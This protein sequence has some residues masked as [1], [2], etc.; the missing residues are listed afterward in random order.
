MSVLLQIEYEG[1]LRPLA[2]W[3]I[4]RFTLN[5]YNA[6]TEVLTLVVAGEAAAADP[7][8]AYEGRVV[9][10]CDGVRVFHGIVTQLPFSEKAA[11]ARQE[12][13]VS[14]PWWW[15]ENIVYGQERYVFADARRPSLGFAP[16][17]VKTPRAVMYQAL[18]GE[19]A[20]A[21]AQAQVAADYAIDRASLLYGGEAP[22]TRGTFDIPLLA[23]WEEA[24]NL[25]CAEVIRRCMRYCRDA[26]AYWDHS[27]EKPQLI[28]ERRA[29]LEEVTL[30]LDAGDRITD[31]KVGSRPD[32]VPRGVVIFFEKSIPEEEQNSGSQFTEFETQV[33]GPDPDLGVRNLVSVL[34][35]SGAGDGAEPVPAGLALNYYNS[36]ATLQW[37]GT[38]VLREADPAFDLMPGKVLNLSNGKA[39]WASMKA[40][41]QSVTIDQLTRQTTVEFGPAAQLGPQDLLDQVRLQKGQGGTNAGQSR[42]DGTSATPQKTTSSSG[43]GSTPTYNAKELE[44]C[45]GGERKK[46]K[47]SLV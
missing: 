10:W 2:Q 40:V 14:G 31:Y 27:G 46:I 16:A 41:I 8:F 42:R 4:E 9:V 5:A 44:I 23:P 34:R 33:A 25:S 37:E 20:S 22:F 36:L 11:G 38:V 24:Y 26:V 19:S 12:Y 35:L 1:E 43:I 18:S 47:V 17:P 13:I 28:I 7:V 45:E 21:G 15:L 32:L 39:A 29:D 30:D 3:G 6:A